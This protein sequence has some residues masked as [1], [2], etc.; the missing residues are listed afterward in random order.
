ML[1]TECRLEQKQKVEM[2]IKAAKM[3]MV[4]CH[5]KLQHTLV[6]TDVILLLFI[7]I[8]LFIF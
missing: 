2:S 6:S 5:L 3:F 7:I 8:F 4:S 1:C